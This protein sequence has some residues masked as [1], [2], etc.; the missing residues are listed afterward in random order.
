MAAQAPKYSPIYGGQSMGFV[1]GQ[2]FDPLAFR[3]FLRGQDTKNQNKMAQGGYVGATDDEFES[4]L[5]M[6]QS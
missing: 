2:K 3:G 1:P 4:L 6:L 5:R